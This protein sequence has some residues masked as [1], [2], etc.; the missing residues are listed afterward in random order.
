M[1]NGYNGMKNPEYRIA[2]LQIP[3]LPELNQG[4]VGKPRFPDAEGH[5]LHSIRVKALSDFRGRRRFCSI[6]VLLFLEHI[7]F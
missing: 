3:T 6:F 2:S 4:Q 5:P 1:R 7:C